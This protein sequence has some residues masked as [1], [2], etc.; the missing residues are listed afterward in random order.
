M[1]TA[2]ASLTYMRM[3][4]FRGLGANHALAHSSKDQIR[5]E[6][7]LQRQPAPQLLSS[8]LLR[9]RSLLFPF[10]APPLVPYAVIPLP[11][12]AELCTIRCLARRTTVCATV[13]VVGVPLWMALKSSKKKEKQDKS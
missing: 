12:T 3:Y 6:G 13:R 7:K 5:T 2:F 1:N 4:R 10:R 11:S 8:V 9:Q